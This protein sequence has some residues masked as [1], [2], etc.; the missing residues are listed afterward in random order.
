MRCVH[1]PILSSPLIPINYQYSNKRQYI[2]TAQ[3]NTVIATPKPSW[4]G[5]GIQAIINQ[6]NYLDHMAA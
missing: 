2:L 5:G 3:P 4:G 6:K 1:K